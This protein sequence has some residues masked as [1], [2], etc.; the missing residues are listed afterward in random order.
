MP[1]TLAQTA[2]ILA[3]GRKP[4]GESRAFSAL[5]RAACAATAT[6][7]DGIGLAL[8]DDR[9]SLSPV[10]FVAPDSVL[11]AG[12]R[13][14]VFR[15]LA[16]PFR[17]PCQ[18]YRLSFHGFK[19]AVE[20]GSFMNPL[21]D[22]RGMPVQDE[23]NLTTTLFCRSNEDGAITP[24][25]ADSR[26]AELRGQFEVGLTVDNRFFL[27]RK[28]G[29]GSMGQVFLAKDLRLDRAVA[30]KVVSHRR[31]DFK[32]LEAVLQREA[33]LG[34]SLDHKGIA[35]VY[36]FGFHDNKSYTIFEYVEGE[37]LRTVFQRRG[38]IPLEESLGIVRDLAAALDFAHVHGVIHRDLK[39]ENICFNKVG[40]FKILDLGVAFD[41]KHDVETGVYSGTPAY[42]SPEQAECRPTD[43]K[44]DQYALGLIVFEMLTGRKV[45]IDG[46][47]LGMLRKQ[48]NE[49]PP[50]PRDIVPELPKNA[51]C[52]LL[53]VLS[54]RPDDRFATCQ[55]FARAFGDGPTKHAGHIVAT[56][57]D[58]R[59]GFYIGHV[60]EESL[61]A[62]R[63]ADELERQHY[64][65][66]F[67]G[68]DAIPGLPFVS[69]STAAIERSQAVVVLVSRPA[70]RSA[71]FE[72]EIAYAHE[73]GCPILP[74]LIDISR[75]EFEKLAP[76]WC[77]RL[78]TSPM[79]EYRR[80][81]PLREILARIVASAATLDIDMDERIA[82]PSVASV[83]PCEGQIWATDANQIDILDLDRVLFRNAAIDDFLN[84]KHRHF[85]SATKGFGKTLLL[86]CKRQLLTQSSASSKHPITM[87]P[88][89]RPYLDFMSEMR[90]LSAKH[91]KPL[92]DLST[93]KRLWSAAF[94][95]SA[96]SHH[97]AVID[98]SEATEVEA[99]SSRI[100]RWLRGAKVQPTVV[101][102]ELTSLRV[103]E[104]NRVIDRTDTFLD[105]KMR[106]IHGGA[107]FFI[108]K[109]DQAI[110]HLSR[111]AWIAIQA[112]LIEAAWETMNANSHLKIF[113]SIRQEAFSNYQ[114]AIKSNLF[115][116]TTSLNYSEEDLQALLD[117]LARCYEGCS[118]F[119]AFLGLN[120]VRHG[121][122]PAPEDS[123]QYVRRHTCG[124][125]RD[126]VAIASEISS[127]RSSLSEK[128][129][130]EIV[131]QTSS[132]VVVS[133]IFDEVRVFLNCLGDQDAR[134]RFFAA[135]PGNILE[136]PEAIRVCEEYNGL[137]PG[138]LEHFG[139]DSSDIFHPFRDLYFAG[140]LGVVQ[141]DPE[142]GTTIQRFRRPLDSLTHSA[143]ELPDSPVFLIHP[144][145]DTFIR[146]QRTRTPFLQFQHVPVGENMLWETYSLTLMRIEQQLQKIEDREFVDLAHQ[147][148]KRV[149]SLLNS[150][151]TPFARVEIETSDEWKA[152]R[153]QEDDEVCFEALLWL[154]ELLDEL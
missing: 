143:A 151:K 37:T 145:L 33:K 124:R 87:I 42:S 97:P 91:E 85:I 94:R 120:V 56:P 88:E 152:L 17:A 63:I 25:W 127:K 142:T 21:V 149:Q 22:P 80:T 5:D 141:R 131:Q 76:T 130:R 154:D 134:L 7:V 65:C 19:P 115:A 67:Y 60:A 74:L 137:E 139:E 79:I 66:W 15:G 110:H 132:I 126:L 86:T 129:L 8:A 35:K 107:C 90:W 81:D 61:V 26:E 69:Q 20:F 84:G 146:S 28:L 38:R 119:A 96:I 89:D 83:R 101:F 48:I 54:K 34:A 114:S 140:L 32:D 78:G 92:S 102:K 49:S 50:R 125:P 11:K 44:S 27:Q 111:D 77:R 105:Q 46:T 148:V 118:S 73:I 108:D 9:F 41:V 59:I 13:R 29:R 104:L 128:R 62:R 58:K 3:V 138:T 52:A 95:I 103:G 14:L 75:E 99:F 70:M 93:T 117:Q 123:F 100:R 45:F 82:V 6:K 31:R 133:N 43:G 40:E 12:L 109:V 36:D 16:S 71:D 116:A 112:G 72:R 113:A 24:D 147:V 10:Q 55:E 18:S 135:I 53:R 150:G 68:R 106:Q 144:A 98:E 136:K 47:T 153:G 57:T 121:R 64:A 2:T 39:P 30:V 4:S 23:A 122:R 51:E 1:S